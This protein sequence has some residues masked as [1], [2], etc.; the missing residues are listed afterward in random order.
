M[1]KKS[2]KDEQTYQFRRSISPPPGP[3]T[4]GS[5]YQYLFD[6]MNGFDKGV[7]YFLPMEE[8]AAR[9]ARQAAKRYANS[10]G[11]AITSR[12]VPNPGGVNNVKLYLK[13]SDKPPERPTPIVAKAIDIDSDGF[14][15]IDSPADDR[16]GAIIRSPDFP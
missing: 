15:D 5:K 1:S 6:A 13:L 9:L 8:G 2:K 4:R 10:N 7:W 14:N 3:S 16:W 11:L 12:I